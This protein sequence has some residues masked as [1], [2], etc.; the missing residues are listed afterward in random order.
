MIEYKTAAF[1]DLDL[2]LTDRDTFRSFLRF[3]YIKNHG[4]WIL[5]PKVISCGILRKFR[6]ISLQ[7]FKEKALVCLNNKSKSEIE[8]IGKYFFENFLLHCFRKPVVQKLKWHQKNKHLT[9]LVSASPDF[10]LT[11][12]S[13]FLK[14]D[15]YECS[16]LAYRN[17]RFI[18]EFKGNDCIEGQ[19]KWRVEILSKK[20]FID[21]K[22]SY[23]YSDHTSDLPLLESVGHPIAVSPTNHLRKI[24]LKRGWEIMKI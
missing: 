4:N 17:G 1:F 3:Q 6:F 7:T 23:A 14:S 8:K 9:Y 24:A 12:V 2:T 20:K 15:G 21:L 10:Y 5:V 19:K 22:K 13:D 16:K 18:G 11:H